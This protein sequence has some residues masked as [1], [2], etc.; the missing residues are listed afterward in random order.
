MTFLNATAKLIATIRGA[1]RPR[2]SDI[3][4]AEQL[5]ERINQ[6]RINANLKPFE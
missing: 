6:S 4:Q 3:Q 5:V 1:K 2:K